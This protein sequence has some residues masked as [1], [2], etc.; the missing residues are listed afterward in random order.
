MS[1]AGPSFT[2][3]LQ[4]YELSGQKELET[5][6]TDPEMLPGGDES[7]QDSLSSI[8]EAFSLLDNRWKLGTLS[9]N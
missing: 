7:Y 8:S 1:L 9:T 6:A 4:S 2:V 5:S 3:K